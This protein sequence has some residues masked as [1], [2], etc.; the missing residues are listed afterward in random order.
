MPSP[1]PSRQASEGR[2]PS[3]PSPVLPRQASEGRTPSKPSPPPPR[4]AS[5]GRHR[6]VSE[7]VT[8]ADILSIFLTLPSA[9]MRLDA[10][11][12]SLAR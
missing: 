1:L 10:W 6:R 11:T 3:T 5:E 4:Q 9:A 8:A 2:A 12:P 7:T